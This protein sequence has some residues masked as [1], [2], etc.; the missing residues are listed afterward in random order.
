M[1]QTEYYGIPLWEEYEPLRRSRANQNYRMIDLALD[2]LQQE[3]TQLVAGS[4]V[5]DGT[6]EQVISLGFTPLAVLVENREGQR[7][8]NGY[9]RYTGLL[10]PGQAYPMGRIV[11]G[12]FAMYYIHETMKIHANNLQMPYYY[13]AVRPN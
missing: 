6:G 12:G 3:K 9:Y 10:L 7:G 11:E 5:G 8:D 4:Y 1:G 2:R 13:L